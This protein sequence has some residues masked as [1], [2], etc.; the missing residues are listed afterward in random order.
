MDSMMQQQKE[1]RAQMIELS[2]LVKN[3]DSRYAS[4]EHEILAQK[5]RVLNGHHK[6]LQEKMVVTEQELSMMRQAK[7]K[8]EESLRNVQEMAFQF[9][10]DQK[11][12]P[13]SHGEISRELDRIYSG[14]RMW[15]KNHAD[16]ELFHERLQVDN[17]PA[18]WKTWT[19]Y[20]ETAFST[21]AKVLPQL[22]LEA[23]LMHIICEKNPHQSTF[24]PAMEDEP[25][26]WRRGP[27]RERS[28][29]SFEK[30]AIYIYG[31]CFGRVDC[32]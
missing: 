2:D 16:E 10:D 25:I 30:G 19:R 15:C 20:D 7:I 23:M 24:F 27:G 6:K 29:Y 17:W 13:E 32:R 4:L 12:A 3:I 22:L 18:E 8:A 9:Q 31:E 28:F 5:F 14:A 11:W 26:G 1:L 21:N